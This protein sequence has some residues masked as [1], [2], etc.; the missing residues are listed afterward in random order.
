MTLVVLLSI[1]ADVIEVVREMCCL[2]RGDVA[3][4]RG[5]H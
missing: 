4:F 1:T 5:N 2:R 3:F